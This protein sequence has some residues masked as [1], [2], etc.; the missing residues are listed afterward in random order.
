MAMK[1]K[2]GWL[3]EQMK[4]AKASVDVWQ[5]WKKDTIRRQISEGFS[6]DRRGPLVSVRSHETG[7]ITVKDRKK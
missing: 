3:K 4:T 2:S 6:T 7:R 5:G 1:P